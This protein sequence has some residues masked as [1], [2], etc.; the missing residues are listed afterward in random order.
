MERSHALPLSIT[1]Y[2]P[3]WRRLADALQG[4]DAAAAPVFDERDYRALDELSAST[5]KDI[6][7]PQWI[8]EHR[9]RARRADLD[10]LRL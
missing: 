4:A 3:W 6:G 10:L 2:R 8:G 9:E 7:A 5:L 1:L